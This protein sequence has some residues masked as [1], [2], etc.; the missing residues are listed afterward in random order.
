MIRG[1]AGLEGSAAYFRSGPARPTAGN[2]TDLAAL[3]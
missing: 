1:A 2:A 3:P